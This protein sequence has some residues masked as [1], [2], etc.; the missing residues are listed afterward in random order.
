MWRAASSYAEVRS[1]G[2]RPRPQA[3]PTFS[4]RGLYA[5]DVAIEEALVG[6]PGGLM[7]SVA[8]QGDLAAT[9]ALV[10]LPGP[11]DSWRS[12]APVLDA[13]PPSMRT[14]AVTPRGHGES[15]KPAH[16][17]RVE[18]FASDTVGL[19][20]VLGVERAILVGH[21]G[22]CPVARRVAID[23]PARVAGLV[24]EAS[25]T[26]LG[27]DPELRNAVTALLATL[28]E[29]MDP[30]LVR[31][32]VVGTSSAA[33]PHDLLELLVEEAAKVPVHVW[34]ETFTALLDYDDLAELGRIAAPARL[35]WGTADQIVSRAMQDELC[36]R[37]PKAT[38]TEYA[39][40]GH[41]PR[42]ET[43]GR[44]AADLA[45]FDARLRLG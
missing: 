45:A 24:L 31:S 22:S 23:H 38:L 3:R 19:L 12:Y 39:G 43:P 4:L 6:L 15:D 7:L 42:W 25:P 40:S 9:E 33:V 21:S 11:T 29:P 36:Q 34:R 41:T 14:I 20:D 2:R 17:Y 37:L 35:I 16:G 5:S 28:P 27:H 10:L 30:E 1:P 32:F 26:A 8:Q 18:D 13:L 44:F